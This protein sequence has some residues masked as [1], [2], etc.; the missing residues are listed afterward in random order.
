MDE[1]PTVG[2]LSPSI[3][4]A[5]IV[6]ALRSSSSSSSISINLRLLSELVDEEVEPEAVCKEQAAA[7]ALSLSPFAVSIEKDVSYGENRSVMA[8]K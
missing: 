1:S 2:I 7:K 4:G 6:E 8:L 3:E 5:L